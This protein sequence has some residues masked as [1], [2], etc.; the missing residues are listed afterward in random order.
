MTIIIDKRN[1]KNNLLQ[2][3]EE[4]QEKTKKVLDK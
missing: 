4:S 3:T 1:A 2:A